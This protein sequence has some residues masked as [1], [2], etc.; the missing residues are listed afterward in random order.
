M[1]LICSRLP[2]E[3]VAA[4]QYLSKS[5]AINVLVLTD[6]ISKNSVK[7]HLALEDNADSH[8]F[9]LNH[10]TFVKLWLGKTKT[11]VLNFNHPQPTT[12][13]LAIILDGK[14]GDLEACIKINGDSVCRQT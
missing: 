12:N 2:N 14:Y 10:F 13:S 8:T 9:A 11:Y 5:C 3:Q 6:G 7:Y 4:G 1:P